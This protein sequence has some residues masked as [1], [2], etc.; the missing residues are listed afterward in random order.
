MQFDLL[1]YFLWIKILNICRLCVCIIYVY[2]FSNVH[3]YSFHCLNL[4][5][6]QFSDRSVIFGHS[7]LAELHWSAVKRNI[8]S[9]WS[10]R[11]GYD[12]AWPGVCVRAEKVSNVTPQQRTLIDAKMLLRKKWK[13]AQKSLTEIR[14]K[15]KQIKKRSMCKRNLSS[16]THAGCIWRY[17]RYGKRDT[18]PPDKHEHGLG[19]S[20]PCTIWKYGSTCGPSGL[21]NPTT[22]G[23]CEWALLNQHTWLMVFN[24]VRAQR[25]STFPISSSSP[26][27][28]YSGLGA[29]ACQLTVWH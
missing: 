12:C 23:R 16:W 21:I 19:L 18:K 9:T 28:L 10:H 7:R 1:I 5:I 13:K 24:Y 14:Q 15:A 8:Q 25:W 17:E 20:W 2:V 11:F 4:H 29:A 6:S 22:W 3:K 26:G 27:S